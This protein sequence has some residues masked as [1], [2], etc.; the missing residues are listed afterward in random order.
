[1][2]DDEGGGAL[3]ESG[4][5][6]EGWVQCGTRLFAAREHDVG[7]RWE[8]GG[9]VE[10]PALRSG[11]ELAMKRLRDGG[12]PGF[13]GLT[14]GMWRAAGGE[15]MD[16]MWRLCCSVWS[17]RGWPGDWCGAV[18][19]PLPE[20]AGGSEGVCK[21]SNDRLDLSCRQDTSEGDWQKSEG[22]TAGRDLGWAGGVP[23]GRGGGGGRRENRWSACET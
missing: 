5:V 13:D 18:F 2:I 1:M 21:S 16:L 11:V 8:G 23:W 15:G 12:S 19:V 3:T 17:G 9:E 22:Q 14:S 6:G 10:P 7:T 20:G 4:D